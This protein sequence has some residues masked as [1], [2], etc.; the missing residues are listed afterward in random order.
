MP[1]TEPVFQYTQERT[2]VY[3][4]RPE[5]NLLVADSWLAREG[6]VR[7]LQLHRKRF[8]SSCEQLAGLNE[9]DIDPFWEIALEKVP[10]TGCWFPRIEMAGSLKKPVFQIRIRKAPLVHQTVRLSDRRITDFRKAPRHKGPD[11]KEMLTIREKIV[12]TDADEGILTTPKGFLL[13]GL[14]TSIIWWENETLCTV[15]PSHRI[16]PGVTAQLIQS[17]ATEKHTRIAHR[18]RK[19]QDLNGCEVWAVNAL[20]GIR[21]AIDWKH[22]PFKP[23]F[24]TDI[25]YWR[26][27]LDRFQENL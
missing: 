4:G 21:Q 20:H 25:E 23:S 5:P 9:K 8:F 24:H 22:A 18:L 17:L 16:L 14:T 7:A 15:P 2:L 1:E 13:E 11:L 26:K 3:T 6:R 12:E 27:A 10:Q 19:P